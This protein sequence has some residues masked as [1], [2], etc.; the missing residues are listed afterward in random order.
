MKKRQY[1]CRLIPL[2]GLR[3]TARPALLAALG[4]LITLPLF[5]V[6]VI[7]VHCR[8]EDRFLRPFYGSRASI[9][10]KLLCEELVTRLEEHP[11][12]HAWE[13]Q[14]RGS[15][16]LSSIAFN[17]RI[18]SGQAVDTTD[19][20]LDL[21]RPDMAVRRWRAVWR[22][23]GDKQQYD[24]PS[25]SDAPRVMA[26]AFEQHILVPEKAQIED[27]LK[28]I[29]I[30]SGRWLPHQGR[31]S[32]RLVSSLRWK[33]H[34]GLRASLFKVSCPSEPKPIELA[35]KGL[36]HPVR[37]DPG[38]SETGFE[39]LAFEVIHSLPDKK[40]V[41]KMLPGLLSTMPSR[42]FLLQYEDPDLPEVY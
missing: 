29:P 30:A 7:T 42:I 11:V 10:E 32:P 15:A 28:H 18:V 38:G 40:K 41:Y 6:P 27:A 33:E 2:T 3:L 16:P 37:Y 35:S 8:I 24:D 21:Q 1:L 36:E 26:E 39:A 25:P 22:E 19:L 20:V 14:A 34:Q 31:D 9:V 23:P 17:F 13:Y 4:L 12:L 5:G